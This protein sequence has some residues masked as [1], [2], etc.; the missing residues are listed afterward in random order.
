MALG[1]TKPDGTGAT[2]PENTTAATLVSPG[3]D[4]AGQPQD[5]AFVQGEAAADFYSDED[6]VEFNRETPLVSIFSDEFLSDEARGQSEPRASGGRG[7]R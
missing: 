2:P 1:Q 7:D 3:S 4:L 6:N 5:V